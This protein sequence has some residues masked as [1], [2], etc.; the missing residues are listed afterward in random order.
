[1][2]DIEQFAYPVLPLRDIVVFPHMI[3]PLFVG[4]EKSVR[5]LEAVMKDDKQILL[6]EPEGRVRGRAERRR[7]LPRRRARQ[8]AAAPEAARRHREGA[9]RGQGP[10]A[11]SR[12]SSTTTPISR[13][14]RSRSPRP[15]RTPAAIK[16]LSRAV[17]EE[18]ERYAKL[19]RNIPEEAVSA[20]TERHDRRRRSSPTPSPGHLGTK[21]EEKQ[22]LLEEAD[23]G[24]RL[25]A[26][27]GL[28]QGEMSRPEGREE[29]QE[30]RQDPDGAHP[31]RVLPERAD[32]G[33]PARARRRG[34]GPGRR[35]RVRGADRQDQALEGGAREGD[36]RAEE[37]AVDVADVGRG[38]GRAQLPRLDAVD[39][40][41][42]EDPKIKKDLGLAQKV[43]DDDHY[44]L[45]KVKDRIVEFLAV[46]SRSDKLKGPI[47]CLVGPPGVGKTSPGQVGGEGHG[48]RVHPHLA[49]RRPGRGGDPRAPA[50]LHRLD[51][52]QDHP[53]DEEGEDRQPADPARRDRQDGPGLPRR[54]GVG[55]CSRCSTP[56]RTR[57]S[58]TTTSRWSTTSAR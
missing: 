47:L 4:R 45:E 53:V 30:P 46:Q 34:R 44:G 36:G 32:E 2:T 52:R 41:G 14:R 55:A 11:G 29:D 42:Q 57:P 12:G 1:M 24:E 22:K 38:H 56:S 58:W 19:N 35:E 5:A 15:R 9:G 39:P 23:V 33:D 49:R 13:P 7:H 50:D 6:A 51:A 8:R 20:V 18:F 21:L 27:Y 37:A 17:A 10:G 43:L 28:M 26:I 48:A 3:V 25:E 54:P 16:A 40:V 31:A